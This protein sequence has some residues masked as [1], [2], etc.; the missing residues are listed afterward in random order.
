MPDVYIKAFRYYTTDNTYRLSAMGLTGFGGTAPIRLQLTD[1]KYKFEVWQNNLLL[2]TFPDE[3][4][5][6]ATK[7]LRL[8]ASN[9]ANYFNTL[10]KITSACS[11]NATDYLICTATDSSGTAD[12]FH[13]R[14]YE[15]QTT[16][17]A[18]ECD[19]SNSTASPAT[20]S[21]LITNYDNRTHYYTF[22]ATAGSSSTVLRGGYL[23]GT[24]TSSY[25]LIGLFIAAILVLTMAL[26]GLWNPA[27]SLTL[28]AAALVITYM[29]GLLVMSATF[30]V[31]MVA[32][33]AIAIIK[34]RS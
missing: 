31:G 11:V 24:L 33:I 10:N 1:A 23:M 29:L 7:E 22:W 25:N 32:V 28:T 13:L 34:V 8:T 12:G 9:L 4:L 2:G 3:Y 16:A 19:I 17:W 5:T 6:A 18:T 26:V 14:V 20:L 15:Y 30:L 27:A 21:C